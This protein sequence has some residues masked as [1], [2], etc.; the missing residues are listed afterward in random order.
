LLE[1]FQ[2]VVYV[3]LEHAVLIFSDLGVLSAD[4]TVS[5]FFLH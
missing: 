1:R 2:N 5:N 4:K 3:L